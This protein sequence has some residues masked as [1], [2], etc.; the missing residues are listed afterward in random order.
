MVEFKESKFYKLLQ[1]F[2]INNDKETF[3]QFLAEFYNKT[4]GII[5][6]N[7]MQDEII[8]ELREMF[9]LFN[10]EGIDENIVR[11]KVN[12]FLE[13][14]EKIQDI[15]TKLIINGNDIKNISSQ[16]DNKVNNKELLSSFLTMDNVIITDEYHEFTETSYTKIIIPYKI[17]GNIIKW[18]VSVPTKWN[19]D[20]MILETP[21]SQC[22]KNDFSVCINGGLVRSNK[23]PIGVTISNGNII[24]SEIMNT[25]TNWYIGINKD[26][27]RFECGKLKNV[28]LEFLKNKYD[29]VLTSFV[30]LIINGEIQDEE[31][32]KDC[33][34]YNNKHP[35]QILCQKEDG[36]V[37]IITSD[38]RRQSQKGWTLLEAQQI[39]KELNVDFAFNLDGGGSA[40]TVYRNTLISTPIDGYHSQERE[41]FSCFGF[42]IGNIKNQKDDDVKDLSHM[43]GNLKSEIDYA[44]NYNIFDRGYISLKFV[45]EEQDRQGIEVYQD[46]MRTNKLQ[47]SKNKLYYFNTENETSSTIFSVDD[48][49]VITTQKGRGHIQNDIAG[50][51]GLE[52]DNINITG[53]YWFLAETLGISGGA[54][55]YALQHIQSGSITALQI[56]TPYSNNASHKCKRR[57]RNTDG[58]WTEWIDNN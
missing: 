36:T 33:P 7:D 11:E 46:N 13:N 50:T 28:T 10:E 32:L 29:N 9:L 57:R 51:G 43:I 39:I 23:M 22:L 30:P 34:N 20:N 1:D 21:R 8:K 52:P 56:A 4:E 2:F 53:M 12:Y 5:I 47:L 26:T 27:N 3:I 18:E 17:N 16:L 55:A 44:K 31:T 35:R 40:Q 6:K 48:S 25:L 38:G 15:I 14:S 58:T 49:G 42:K 45:G 54:S 41:V 37:I 19:S 24:T